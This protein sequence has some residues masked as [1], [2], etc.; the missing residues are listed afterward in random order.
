MRKCKECEQDLPL[1]EFYILNKE[2]GWRRSK[3]KKCY[4][5]TNTSLNSLR[6]YE[7]Y[8]DFKKEQRCAKCGNDDHRVLEFDHIDRS[9]KSFNIGDI[10]SKGY[11]IKRLQEEIDKCEVL[12]ANC[13]RIKTYEERKKSKA[14]I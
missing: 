8:K 5:K 7:W 3:C 4:Y 12:C 14:C 13:H 2:K 9:T 10:A 6:V 1:E 11:S